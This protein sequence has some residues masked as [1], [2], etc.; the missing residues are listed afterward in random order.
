MSADRSKLSI[1]K[2]QGRLV[3][4]QNEIIELWKKKMGLNMDSDDDEDPEV[5]EEM[6]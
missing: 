6:M 5:I 4:L 2:L 3:K 1:E